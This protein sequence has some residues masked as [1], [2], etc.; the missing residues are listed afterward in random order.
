MAGIKSRNVT[1]TF[2]G[3]SDIA[4]FDAPEGGYTEKTS[5]ADVTASGMSLGQVVEDSTSWEGEDP[6]NDPIK[7]EQGDII[8]TT[9]TAG[10]YA[11]SCDVADL[12]T[13]M[14][15]ALMKATK[16]DASKLTSAS[17]GNV[18][19]AVKFI[20]LP[21]VTRPIAIF[22]DEANK[23]I[24]FPKAKI[25]GNLTLD[26]KLWRLHI[27]ATAEYINTETLGTFMMGSGNPIAAAGSEE[28]E[29]EGQTASTFATKKSS[30]M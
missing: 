16:V 20:E 2:N 14:A 13:E 27:T 24:L 11:F 4:L 10:T 7:D 21:V 3:Q 30:S 15:E 29:P 5:F 25:V 1:E 26:S 6:S 18:T 17:I 8:V 22:N 12:S 28:Q 9:V 19:N 23:W